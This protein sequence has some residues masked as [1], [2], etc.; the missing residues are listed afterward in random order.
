MHSWGCGK[1]ETETESE[2]NMH[3]GKDEIREGISKHKIFNI[4]TLI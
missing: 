2:T 1:T 3:M 4:F